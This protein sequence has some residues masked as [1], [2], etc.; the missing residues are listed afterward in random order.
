MGQVTRGVRKNTR[1]EK[2]MDGFC[3]TEWT[4]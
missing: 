3:L 4:I 1:N 2:W